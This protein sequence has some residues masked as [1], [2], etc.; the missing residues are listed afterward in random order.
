MCVERWEGSWSIVRGVCLPCGEGR[1][2]SGAAPTHRPLDSFCVWNKAEAGVRAERE[3]PAVVSSSGRGGSGGGWSVR[4]H[5][6]GEECGG[7]GLVM[8]CSGGLHLVW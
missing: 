2:L 1:G 3:T 8:E 6:G 4:E 7:R 5:D